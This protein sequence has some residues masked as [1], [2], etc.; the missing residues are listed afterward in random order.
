VC[1]GGL[2]HAFYSGLWGALLRFHIQDASSGGL[3]RAWYSGLWE[4]LLRFHIQGVCI[5]D[6]RR[7]GDNNHAFASILG[8]LCV[9]NIASS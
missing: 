9:C 8:S 2:P 6:P 4:A 1:S 3:P 7:G 5:C